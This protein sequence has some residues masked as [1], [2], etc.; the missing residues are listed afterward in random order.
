MADILAIEAGG[1]LAGFFV[2]LKHRDLALVDYFAI[3]P[4]I[5]GGGIGSTA[6]GQLCKLYRGKRLF[7]EIE[8]PLANTPN[9]EQR[10]RRKNFYHRNG[11]TDTGIAM[12]VY[13]TD[14]ELLAYQCVITFEEYVDVLRSIFG[15]WV[16]G[17]LHIQKKVV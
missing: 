1:R 7:L 17:L 9:Y 15:R 16:K 4:D 14:M 6:L 2:V 12:A 10:I 8:A 13:G 11:F 3:H 5:R